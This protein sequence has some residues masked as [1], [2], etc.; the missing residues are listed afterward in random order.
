MDGA[1]DPDVDAFYDGVYT[2]CP[3]LLIRYL[4]AK[5]PS[6]L[7]ELMANCS[8]YSYSGSLASKI[9]HVN[10]AVA[11]CEKLL[12]EATGE[13]ISKMCAALF[14]GGKIEGW[15]AFDHWKP[16][17][18]KVFF[19]ESM[20]LPSH[21]SSVK[22]YL[23]NGRTII[24]SPRIITRS[25]IFAPDSRKAGED[26]LFRTCDGEESFERYI[27]TL[28]KGRESYSGEFSILSDELMV[29]YYE[30]ETLYDS[31][32]DTSYIAIP[33]VKVAQYFVRLSK[34]LALRHTEILR[35]LLGSTLLRSSNIIFQRGLIQNMNFK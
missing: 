6:I 31:I 28:P 15:A 3:S 27:L 14:P 7:V 26:L 33:G 9:I 4:L 35:F 10:D 24:I 8:R 20:A 16:D 23:E 18:E 13:E 1:I 11:S 19:D 29:E 2:H 32:K 21:L 17:K 30:G 25:S 34:V 5:D 22:K 12:A